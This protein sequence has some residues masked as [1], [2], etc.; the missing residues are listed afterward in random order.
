MSQ[1]ASLKYIFGGNFILLN[2]YKNILVS[3][4]TVQDKNTVFLLDIMSCL[5]FIYIA[6]KPAVHAPWGGDTLWEKNK[7]SITIN[8]ELLE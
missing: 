7:L 4:A 8:L 1:C 2:L 5:N 6:R 3:E